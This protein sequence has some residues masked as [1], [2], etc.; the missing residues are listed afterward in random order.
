MRRMLYLT[1]HRWFTL[2]LLGLTGK[3][4]GEQ[5]FAL[6]DGTVRSVYEHTV[7]MAGDIPP[8]WIQSLSSDSPAISFQYPANEKKHFGAAALCKLLLS[9]EDTAA[10]KLHRISIKSPEQRIHHAA[11]VLQAHFFGAKFQGVP[12]CF[13][14]QPFRASPKYFPVP[15][16]RFGQGKILEIETGGKNAIELA[17]LGTARLGYLLDTEG[18]FAVCETLGAQYLL[19]PDTL[20]RR[21]V[22]QFQDCLQ[23]TVRQLLHAPYSFESL[24]YANDGKRALKDQVDALLDVVGG[25]QPISGH[26]VLVLPENADKDLHNYIKRRLH[27]RVQF[28]CVCAGKVRRFF[29]LDASNGKARYAV[30]GEQERDFSSYLRYTAMGLLLVNRQWPWV[31]E[32]GTHYDAYIGV[33][34]LRNTAVFTFFYEGGRR[35]FVRSEESQQKEKVPRKKIAAVVYRYLKEDLEGT[36]GKLR[37]L[38]L[39]RDGRA[40][41]EEWL[42]FMDAVRNLIAEGIL[43]NDVKVGVVE[44]HKKFSLGLRLVAM[45]DQGRFL[46]PRIGSFFELNEHEG[47]LCTTGYPFRFDGT[48]KPLYVRV[49]KGDLDVVKVLEDTFAMSQLCWPVP[50]RCM[51]LPIDLKLCDDLLRATASDADDEEALYGEEETDHGD[52]AEISVS[53]PH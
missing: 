2:Q 16:Q 35:C 41:N 26:G 31:L 42:G 28:Q 30:P 1:G 20:D 24:V 18:G 8:Q 21:I 39:R 43:P 22:E 4:I 50:N 52:E 19:A 23:N 34:V 36:P 27:G 17:K 14:T 7:L 3:S 44:V 5:R 49:V 10:S 45:D 33:D 15:A 40:F 9:P 25:E 29:R 53:S 12:V 37:W 6:E 13:D 11:R 46:N 47:L 51:R 48:V 38:V 32:K